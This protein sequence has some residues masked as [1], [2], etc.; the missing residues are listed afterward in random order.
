MAS[1]T[2]TW[3]TSL[4][5][6]RVGCDLRVGANGASVPVP[7]EPWVSVDDVST[8]LVQRCR[9]SET[10][11]DRCRCRNRRLAGIRCRLRHFE[12]IEATEPRDLL[13]M[14][15]AF[16]LTNSNDVAAVGKLRRFAEGRSVPL[17]GTHS[18]DD[19]IITLLAAGFARGELGSP[20][21][22]YARLE[23]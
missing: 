19:D 20:A 2:R 10:V 6:G 12:K 16:G 11:S 1:K 23:S 3:R 17:A 21:I 15:D 14:L 7:T 4:L 18:P 13:H 22:P 8:H 5:V 9:C